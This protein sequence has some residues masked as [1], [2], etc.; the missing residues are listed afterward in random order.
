LR[1][2][3]EIEQ[4]TAKLRDAE[5][6]ARALREQLAAQEASTRQPKKSWWWPW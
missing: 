6:Q 4:Y 2:E 5:A 3:Q 1:E